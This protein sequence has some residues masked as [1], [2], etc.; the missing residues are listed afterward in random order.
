MKI[1]IKC[2]NSSKSLDEIKLI[3]QKNGGTSIGKIFLGI[4]TE[5]IIILVITLMAFVMKVEL[6]IG[7]YTLNKIKNIN[8]EVREK[9]DPINLENI[10]NTSTYDGILMYN[11]SINMSKEFSIKVSN[12]FKNESDNSG[13]HYE[14]K[15]NAGSFS[16]C[17]FNFNA[18]DGYK[19]SKDLISQIH[20]Y[21]SSSN[22]TPI[23]TKK[24]NNIT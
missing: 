14:Y 9:I 21:Y 18:I 2:K 11:T 5:A 3:C 16:T 20:K 6:I 22:P 17:K 13:Y 24:I 4:F 19:E 23:S 8:N 12:V 7:K 15:N 1:K 10:T